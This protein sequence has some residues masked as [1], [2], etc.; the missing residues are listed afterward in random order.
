[1][2]T[3]SCCCSCSCCCCYP[4]GNRALAPAPARARFPTPAT[5]LLALNAVFQLSS[6]DLAA[7]VSCA[8]AACVPLL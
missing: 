7:L 3:R 1:M 4:S 2:G 8:M 6:P 5:R